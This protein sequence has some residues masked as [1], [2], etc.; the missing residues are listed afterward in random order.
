MA[1]STNITNYSDVRAV[2]DAA[3]ESGGANYEVPATAE[4]IKE[5]GPVE[6]ALRAAKNWRFRAY[7]FRTLFRKQENH[8]LGMRPEDFTPSTPYDNIV[9]PVPTDGRVFI[10]VEEAPSG[11]LTTLDGKPLNP[12]HAKPA[13]LEDEFARAARELA[14]EFG[15]NE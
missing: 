4:K 5:F 7:Y 15:D 10:T 2:L 13:Q 8:R 9:L 11:K 12:Q 3:L 6:A 1:Q 14:Q